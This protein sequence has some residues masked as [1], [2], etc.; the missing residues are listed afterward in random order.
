MCKKLTE[1]FNTTSSAMPRTA[2]EKRTLVNASEDD[3]SY[4]E[5][6]DEDED[7]DVVEGDS[8][9]EE[10]GADAAPDEEEQSG[11]GDNHGSAQTVGPV[12]VVPLY[13]MLTPEDQA[14]AFAPAPPGHRLVVVATNVAETSVTLPGIS[15][16]VD[17][18]R[19][20]RRI[21]HPGSSIS[22][23]GVDWISQVRASLLNLVPAFT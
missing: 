5:A 17:S 3:Q 1:E 22:S 20:K 23:F 6:D 11:E 4:R 21:F 9:E 2:R 8:D 19:S 13:A 7:A 16:V 10:G 15:Y 18:G 12:W 14:R